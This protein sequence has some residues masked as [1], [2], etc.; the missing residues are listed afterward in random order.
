MCPTQLCPAD[1][2]HNKSPYLFCL[3]SVTARMQTNTRGMLIMPVHDISKI[4]PAIL[5]KQL[6]I[7]STCHPLHFGLLAHPVRSVVFSLQ[8]CLYTLLLSFIF[9]GGDVISVPVGQTDNSLS[10]AGDRRRDLQAFIL[11]VTQG[12]GNPRVEKP[13]CVCLILG[14]VCRI[15]NFSIDDWGQLV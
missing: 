15:F 3:L 13:V 9:L 7:R 4:S 5:S 10:A 11:R 6:S 14:K 2:N 8:G 12:Q 1:E